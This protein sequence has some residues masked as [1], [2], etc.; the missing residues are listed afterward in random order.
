MTHRQIRPLTPEFARAL[1]ECH[2]A[3]WREAYPGL[4]PAHVLD[5]FQVEPLARRWTRDA[6][7][8]PGCVFVAVDGGTVTGF[9]AAKPNHAADAIAEVEL[10]AIYVRSA[11][12]GTGLA[13]ELLRVALDPARSCQLWVFEANPRAQ[14]FY[15]RHGFALDGGR[16]VEEFTP[17][18]Q[19][20]MV[21]PG[22][23][24]R[25]LV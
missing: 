13:D 8:N 4:V 25:V 20:R 11:W 19:V 17:A 9:A 15:R 18:V 23:P 10:N 1:A 16:K 24:V 7:R 22:R 6:E 5:A 21:R 2:I 3:C 14:A 12:Y